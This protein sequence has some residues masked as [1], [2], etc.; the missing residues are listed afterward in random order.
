MEDLTIGRQILEGNEWMCAVK[1]VSS[2]G[3]WGWGQA[4]LSN[5]SAPKFEN[6]GMF[7]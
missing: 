5:T 1:S 7:I 2:W 4:K 3:G 6:L